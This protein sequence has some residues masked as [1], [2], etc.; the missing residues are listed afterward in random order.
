[1]T[2]IVFVRHFEK[3]AADNLSRTRNVHDFWQCYPEPYPEGYEENPEVSISFAGFH[4][5]S[6]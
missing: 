2:A 4:M 5:Q 6:I 3:D 1:M